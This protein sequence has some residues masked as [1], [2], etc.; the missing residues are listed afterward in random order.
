MSQL[1]N[2]YNRYLS[3][4]NKYW[5]VFIIFVFLTFTVGDSTLY[6]RFIYD[7]KI[8]ELERDIRLYEKD[9]EVS[10]KKLDDLHADKDR[11]EKYA[12]EEFYMKKPDEDVFIIE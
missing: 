7:Q 3:R 9:I 11:L 12:R 6:N 10:R 8:R 5:L 2:F 1:K 4:L